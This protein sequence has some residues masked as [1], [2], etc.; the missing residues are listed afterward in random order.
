MLL[1]KAARTAR[2][3]VPRPW[4]HPQALVLQLPNDFVAG[5]KERKRESRRKRMEGASGAINRSP[6]RTVVQLKQQYGITFSSSFPSHK[7]RHFRWDTRIVPPLTFPFVPDTCS[8][9]VLVVSNGY[10][11]NPGEKH[12]H[13][14]TVKRQ[15]QVGCEVG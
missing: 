6:D 14:T 4:F 3:S 15:P 11:A 1:S 9:G 13:R 10:E 12:S 2:C 5:M 8:R 7:Q